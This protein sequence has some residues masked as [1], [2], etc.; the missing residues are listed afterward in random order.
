MIP[1]EPTIVDGFISQK[2]ATYIN[3]YLRNYTQKN[4]S[5]PAA[6][7]GISGPY[8]DRWGLTS[9]PT[10]PNFR[11]ED[12]F[13]LTDLLEM[14][15]K[16]VERVFYR[17]YDI[18][19]GSLK[20]KNMIYNV[21]MEGSYTPEHVDDTGEYDGRGQAQDICYSALIYLTDDYTGGEITFPLVNKSIKP[22]PGTL[23][24]FRG[25]ERIPHR[26]E[27]VTGGERCN[28]IIFFE[29]NP[30]GEFTTLD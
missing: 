27:T 12:K 19:K 13:I 29:V 21:Q 16:N 1:V 30:Q 11:D 6:L 15:L 4:E 18:E 9:R 17:D 8:I 2:T 28:L 20:F 7:C 14:T 26:V 5:I 22:K 3:S 24:Y 10:P 25:D 23:V